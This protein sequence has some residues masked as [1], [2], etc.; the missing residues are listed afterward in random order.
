LIT[1]SNKPTEAAKLGRPVTSQ[2]PI[3]VEMSDKPRHEMVLASAF[4]CAML[5]HHMISKLMSVLMMN[6]SMTINIVN[7]IGYFHP[8]NRY[9]RSFSGARL[10]CV[11]AEKRR[12]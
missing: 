11:T 7:Y 3:V 4:R 2:T 1:T 10:V 6:A 9:F 12:Q 8:V 5:S